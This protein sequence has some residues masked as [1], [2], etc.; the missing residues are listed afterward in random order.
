MLD[1]AV[2]GLDIV[3]V[4]IGDGR[5][6]GVRDLAV[7]ALVVV[8]CQDLPVEIARHIPSVIEGVVLEVVL[9]EPGLLVDALEVV[10][11]GD[12]GGFAGVQVHPD[13]SV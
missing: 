4:E 1:V 9:L 10:F 6:V 3:G 13:E 5:D 7:V 11:P 2:L 12:L 8:V